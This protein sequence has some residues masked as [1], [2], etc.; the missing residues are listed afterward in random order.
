MTKPLWPPPT[1]TASYLDLI[2][3][4]EVV[5]VDAAADAG[6]D[7][8]DTEAWL[9]VDILAAHDDEGIL[10]ERCGEN[11]NFKVET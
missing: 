1:I 5:D 2:L 6:D 7:A 11:A 10:I 4:A 8:K 3:E 9:R